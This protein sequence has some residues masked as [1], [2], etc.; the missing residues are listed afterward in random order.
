M[1]IDLLL[2]NNFTVEIWNLSPIIN[3]EIFSYQGDVTWP[4]PDKY[5]YRLIR[6]KKDY[7]HE[8]L[9]LGASDFIF[10]NVGCTRRT[11]FVYR[12]IARKKLMYGINMNLL[13]C[14]FESG[15]GHNRVVTAVR[16]AAFL[17][18]LKKATVKK[19]AARFTA[20]GKRRFM[21]CLDSGFRLMRP[22][23]VSP[24]SYILR[25]GNKSEEF[26]KIYDT[27]VSSCT[28]TVLAHNMDYDFYL[29]RKDMP[30][31]VN[32]KNTVVFL[33]GDFCF[34]PNYIRSNC[35]ISVTPEVYF[36][37]L[38]KFFREIENKWNVEVIIAAH[39]RA[40]GEYGRKDYFEGRSVISCR[41]PELVAD[42][43]FVILHWSMSI[44]YAVLF[45]KPAVFMTT[46]QLKKGSEA[47]FIENEAAYFGKTPVNISRP[48]EV[49]D[50][51]ANGK[52][53]Y[54]EK[55]YQEYKDNYIKSPGTPEKLR[56]ELTIDYL[57][58]L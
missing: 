31:S 45:K 1:G 55:I 15:G 54:D 3:P 46:D 22:Y 47:G 11:F 5:A 21:Q 37:E 34:H 33:D 38:C 18:R 4:R 20:I 42:S 36:P 8:I 32:K 35:K 26:L 56:W 40:S 49:A 57:K 50:F 14:Y 17:D 16:K 29:L 12:A 6:T 25:G 52:L 13:E 51:L 53:E 28:K 27:P 9:R 19:I 44:N 10:M 48:E 58:T 43:Q 7:E 39:P 30:G 23:F 41:T 24:A 2:K